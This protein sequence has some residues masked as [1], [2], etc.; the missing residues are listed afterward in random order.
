MKKLFLILCLLIQSGMGWCQQIDSN[1]ISVTPYVA[2]NSGIPASAY[3]V[4]ETKLTNIITSAGMHASPNQAFIL[5]AHIVVLSEDVTATTPPQYA[6]TLGINLYFGDG[7]N[8]NL[9]SSADFEAKGVGTSKAK[10]YLMAL[11][12]LNP[13]DP[14]LKAMLKEGENRVIDYYLSQGPSI[15]REAQTLANNQQYDQAFY[16]LD[17]IPSAC[18]ALYAQATALKMDIYNKII[19]E[20]GASALAEARAVWN[21]GQDRVAAD[22]AGRILAKINPQSPAYREAQML[23]SQI[24]ER[25]NALDNREW[26][27]TLQ[28]Q[29]DETEVR[30]ETLRAAKEVAIAQAKNQPKTVYRIYWW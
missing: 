16:V 22:K 13:K 20:E 6:Y 17:Q 9:Y 11:K 21:A 24:A 14:K 1:G 30:K 10:A 29:R 15:I 18:P 19:S 27:F 23:A 2:E 8:G 4:L 3:T 5:T 7:M 12:N 28:Q 26:N 25:V